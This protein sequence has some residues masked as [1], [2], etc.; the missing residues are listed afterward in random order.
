MF[1]QRLQ[2]VL[3]HQCISLHPVVVDGF[4]ILKVVGASVSFAQRRINC[5]FSPNKTPGGSSPSSDHLPST[6]R[7]VFLV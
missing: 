1:F 3:S 4:I 2:Q 5:G 7:G 6:W